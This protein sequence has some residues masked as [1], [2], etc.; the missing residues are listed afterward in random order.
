[1]F[2]NAAGTEHRPGFRGAVAFHQRDAEFLRPN[3]AR[4]FLYFFRTTNYITQFREI[5]RL[6]ESCVT[7]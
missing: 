5:R 2:N 7:V 6:P 1:M 4:G 3:I